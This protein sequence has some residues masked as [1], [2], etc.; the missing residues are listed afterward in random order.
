MIVPSYL[1]KAFWS[2]LL[3]SHF[4]QL[5]FVGYHMIQ[6]DIL[7]NNHAGRVRVIPRNYF[8]ASWCRLL[9]VGWISP[10]A[11]GNHDVQFGTNCRCEKTLQNSGFKRFP[12]KVPST[13][14]VW[15]WQTWSQVTEN[16]SKKTPPINRD[17]WIGKTVFYLVN[18]SFTFQIR[19][20]E[21]NL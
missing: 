21:G 7:G 19:K 2:T 10:I 14:E 13:I 18:G 6:Y 8:C 3:P 9:W 12:N 11:K 15:W 5:C 17:E 20:E 4:E 16:W 1:Y